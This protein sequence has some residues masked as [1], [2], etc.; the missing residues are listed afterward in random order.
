M[1]Y[2]VK[3]YTGDETTQEQRAL[4]AQRFCAAL[5]ASLGDASLVVPMYTMYQRLVVTFGEMPDVEVM[6]QA[7]REVFESWQQAE[8]AAVQA[9]FG[10]HRYLDEGGY[11]LRLG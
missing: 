4:A 1:T 5:E 3:I 6:N 10:E 11:E 9:A 8:T 2:T 7:E